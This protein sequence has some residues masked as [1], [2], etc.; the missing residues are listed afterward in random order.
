M[1]LSHWH[2]NS[3]LFH[4]S[5]ISNQSML[6]YHIDLL[7]EKVT[8]ACGDESMSCYDWCWS[9][10]S[11]THFLLKLLIVIIALLV[12]CLHTHVY[13]CHR[14]S[15][16]NSKILIFPHK[17]IK[18]YWVPT[19][20]LSSRRRESWQIWDLES[21]SIHNLIV[22]RKIMTHM[23]W[24][25]M[26]VHSWHGVFRLWSLLTKIKVFYTPKQQDL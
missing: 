6:P 24:W 9:K 14:F 12:L 1:L 26:L 16:Y 20:H 4:I 3:H 10:K 17:W 25:C 19:T 13:I 5:T 22:L 21:K 23:R 15:Y 18:P 8:R 11:P 2:L 7:W